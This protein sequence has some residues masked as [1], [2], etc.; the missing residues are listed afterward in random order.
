MKKKL[1]TFC[2]VVMLALFLCSSAYAFV[3][4]GMKW[5]S[6][7]LT[8]YVSFTGT[9]RLEYVL[10][11]ADFTSSTNINLSQTSSSSSY[12]ILCTTANLSLVD[13]DGYAYWSGSGSVTTSATLYLNGTYTNSYSTNKRLSVASHEFGHALGLG[14]LSSGN[15]RLMNGYTYNR[16]EV[17]GVYTPTIGEIT[18][19]AYLY[20]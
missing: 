15:A 3:T 8:Y 13:W 4:T 20:P 10:G 7:S 5:A 18:G 1:T 2:L 19:I 11:A 9:G 14:D 12:D 6:N 17:Y 16:F